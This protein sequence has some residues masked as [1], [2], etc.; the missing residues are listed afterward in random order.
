MMQSPKAKYPPPYRR[1]IS[2]NRQWPS[3]NDK[4]EIHSPIVIF[5]PRCIW[6]NTGIKKSTQS[7]SKKSSVKNIIG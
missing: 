4:G 2:T 1:D 5:N 7:L 3:R 6:D